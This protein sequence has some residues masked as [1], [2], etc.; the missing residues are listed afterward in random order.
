MSSSD[1]LKHEEVEDDDPV[2]LSPEALQALLEF[3]KESEELDASEQKPAT[4]YVL[5]E[6]WVCFLSSSLL[7]LLLI[8]H[9]FISN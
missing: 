6:D 8:A 1:I 9:L 2:T 3:Y 4:C 5:T 7:F